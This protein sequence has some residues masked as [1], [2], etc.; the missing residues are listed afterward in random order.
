MPLVLGD[1]TGASRSIQV[2][3][4][5]ECEALSFYLYSLEPRSSH[6]GGSRLCSFLRGG[7]SVS[8]P[9]P[10]WV[11]KEP[12]GGFFGDPLSVPKWG[13]RDALYK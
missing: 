4:L 7:G 2:F 13:F 6:Y 8:L 3:D 11:E 9:L 1:T 12:Y 10:W 5:A